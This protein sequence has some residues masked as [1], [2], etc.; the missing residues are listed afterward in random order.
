MSVLKPTNDL[1]EMGVLKRERREEL[2]LTQE[3]LAERANLSRDT[4]HRIELGKTSVKVDMFLQICDAL[5][6]T[7][8]YLSPTRYKKQD[9][10]NDLHIQ[11]FRL[12]KANQKFLRK[13]IGEMI[14]HFLFLQ[15]CNDS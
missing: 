12:T 9:E 14:S 10:K 6:T 1:E 7:P 15:G 5:E 2:K 4:I 8:Y 3:E 13:H 11:F